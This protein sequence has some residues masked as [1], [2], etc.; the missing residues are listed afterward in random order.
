MDLWIIGNAVIRCILSVEWRA[1]VAGYF[2][3]VSIV[4]GF[5]SAPLAALQASACI[6]S[7]QKTW[8]MLPSLP[9]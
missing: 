2:G 8:R 1:C 3:C 5:P 6:A 4:A 9:R 7:S